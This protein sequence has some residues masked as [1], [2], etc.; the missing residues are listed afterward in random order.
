MAT[1]RERSN[2]G[3]PGAL[4][5]PAIPDVHVLTGNSSLLATNTHKCW[6]YN[7]LLVSP[8]TGWHLPG[9]VRV[10]HEGTFLPSSQL[11]GVSRLYRTWISPPIHRQKRCLSTLTWHP[12]Q[13]VESGSLYPETYCLII[14]LL[15]LENIPFAMILYCSLDNSL[16]F[17]PEGHTFETARWYVCWQQNCLCSLSHP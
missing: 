10:V 9:Y 15:K 3:N 16:I 13:L 7:T 14:D 6:I 17:L 11:N 4:L 5:P 2:R 8:G 1:W 12:G